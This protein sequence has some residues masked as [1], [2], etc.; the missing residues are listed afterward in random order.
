MRLHNTNA[1]LRDKNVA[2]EYALLEIVAELR[3]FGS[4]LEKYGL[5]PANDSLTKLPYMNNTDEIDLESFRNE[6]SMKIILLNEEQMKAFN[7][8]VS[9]VLPVVTGTEPF[10]P[11]MSSH[12]MKKGGKVFFLEA[13]GSTGKTF[14]IQTIQKLLIYRERK[15]IA[16]ATS[17]VAASLL[18]KGRTAHSTFKIPIPCHSTTTCKISVGSELSQEMREADLIIWDEVVICNRY[19]IEAVER[20][21]RD[22]MRT[23]VS[24][25]G[26]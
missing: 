9:A 24:F 6:A 4:G 23:E 10:Q 14:L 25:G 11:V 3:K 16:V 22:I 17:P 13:P 2:K 21:L 15:V 19:C 12:L 18:Y 7:A 5:P 20:T 8:V 26:K 1:I